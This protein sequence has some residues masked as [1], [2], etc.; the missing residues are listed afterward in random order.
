M[1][2][3]AVTPCASSEE[4]GGVILEERRDVVLD[5]VLWWI[6]RADGKL[7][8]VDVWSVFYM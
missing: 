5:F 1:I 7:L 8:P 4:N 6:R 2:G 3:E